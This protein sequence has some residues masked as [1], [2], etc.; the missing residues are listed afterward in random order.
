M[1]MDQRD[2]AILASSKLKALVAELDAG[3]VPSS[4]IVY[5][6]ASISRYV[7]ECARVIDDE[8]ERRRA[9]WHSKHYGGV[10]PYSVDAV[11]AYKPIPVSAVGDNP[12]DWKTQ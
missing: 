10:D 2:V 1:N 7:E 11:S 5:R 6:L 3:S 9:D 4:R 12:H 8:A